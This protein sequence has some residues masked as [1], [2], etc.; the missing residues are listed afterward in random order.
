MHIS[1]KLYGDMC[2]ETRFNA[3]PLKERAKAG[4]NRPHAK[5]QEILCNYS[6][7]I[8]HRRNGNPLT[9]S[10]LQRL[11][12]LRFVPVISFSADSPTGEFD[13]EHSPG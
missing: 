13:F 5:R 1:A 6:K 4:R 9:V 3:E 11:T 7:I 10:V 12:R 2:G 8:I